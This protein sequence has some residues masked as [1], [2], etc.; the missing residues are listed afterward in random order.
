M[1]EQSPTVGPGVSSLA[2]H[3]LE[4]VIMLLI[5]AI[6]GY[7]LGWLF[8]SGAEK[9]KLEEARSHE[10]ELSNKLVTAENNLRYAYDQKGAMD[11]QFAEMGRSESKLRGDLQIAQQE[12]SNLTYE[13]EICNKHRQDLLIVAQP[14]E[15]SPTA[16]GIAVTTD[17]APKEPS[18]STDAGDDLEKI[19]GVGPKIAAA[20]RMAGIHTFQQLSEANVDG[21]R[22]KLSEI[23]GNAMFDPTTWPKQ[24]KL[25]ADGHWDELKRYQDYLVGGR[26]PENEAALSRARSYF[27]FDFR[28]N[29]LK[30]IEGIGPKIEELFHHHGIYSW[31]QLSDSSYEDCKKVLE[32]GGDA[33]KMHDPTTWPEQAALAVEGKWDKLKE[34]Q[35]YLKGGRVVD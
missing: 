3:T 33:Y 10:N 11:L 27:D 20:L 26:I 13:L 4:I 1:F 32:A 19:E 35:D 28:W 17:K 16:T 9:K 18:L 30:L 2:N 24:A 23:E 34:L 6:L 5:A 7:I 14:P 12:I 21:L 29:D 15:V 8:A 31:K 25:A 22:T